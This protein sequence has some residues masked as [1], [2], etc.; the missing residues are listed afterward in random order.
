M[1]IKAKRIALLPL[2][3]AATAVLHAQFTLVGRPVHINGFA[4]QGFTYSNDNNYLTMRTSEGSLAF[5]DGGVN[6]SA[7]IT[8]KLRVGAQL[9]VRNIGTLGQWHPVLDWA[10]ADYKFKAWFGVRA[11]RVKTTLGLYTDTQD[12]EFL[13]TWAILPQSLYPLDLRALTISHL[14][15]DIYGNIPLHKHLGSLSYTVYAGR[16]RE[17][18]YGGFRD[19]SLQ[20]GRERT[21]GSGWIAGGDLRWV[22]PAPGVTVG[23]SWMHES[24]VGEGTVLARGTPYTFTKETQTSIFYADYLL[25]NLHLSGEYSRN[26]R[27]IHFAGIPGISLLRQDT[28]AWCTSVAYRISKHLELGTYH[29]RFISD[30]NKD[31]SA[32]SNHIYDQTVTARVD[33]NRHWN[34]KVEGHFIDGYSSITSAH[35]F[36]LAQNPH[37][38]QPKTS[39]LVVRTGFNF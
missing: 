20:Q 26:P 2:V 19:V 13:H 14:G 9:Y 7:S 32:H 39:M 33:I 15:G 35:G 5:T 16:S 11:G 12:M 21:G 6:M 8:D 28:L 30:T 38:F 23:A 17:D 29:S 31:W 37:G 10:S 34:F 25:G 24:G 1:D 3:C 4:S 36:Y 18:K 27:S 22:N